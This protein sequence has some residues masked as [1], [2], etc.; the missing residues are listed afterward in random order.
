MAA[1]NQRVHEE[2]LSLVNS[3]ICVSYRYLANLLDITFDNSKALLNEFKNKFSES[4]GMRIES[5]ACLALN[6]GSNIEYVLV[7]GFQLGEY[8]ASLDGGVN[9]V[10]EFVYSIFRN[11]NSSTMGKEKV[12]IVYEQMKQTDLTQAK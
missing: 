2:I 9:V 4:V 1:D 10:T 12:N 3:D 5:V 6:R 8:K 7:P 11:S